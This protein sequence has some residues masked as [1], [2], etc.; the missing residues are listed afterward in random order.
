MRY[1][2]ASSVPHLTKYWP[3]L[4]MCAIS[5]G[6]ISHL[7]L[8]KA[9]SSSPKAA[10][11]TFRVCEQDRPR[12]DWTDWAIPR[13][14]DMCRSIPSCSYLLRMLSAEMSPYDHDWCAMGYH[15]GNIMYQGSGSAKVVICLADDVRVVFAKTQM[16]VRL[17]TSWTKV[18]IVVGD[19]WNRDDATDPIVRQIIDLDADDHPHDLV[20]H[21]REQYPDQSIAIG[22]LHNLHQ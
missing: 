2:S 8:P 16:H 7:T 18:A 3:E 15:S 20:C 6:D 12:V 19:S 21:R 1:Q 14:D 5:N 4:T 22:I 9:A 11:H 17:P 10:R 13:P